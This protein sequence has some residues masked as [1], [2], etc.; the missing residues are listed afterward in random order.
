MTAPAPGRG[1]VRNL[2]P[3]RSQ[4]PW[5]APE[6]L[7]AL[8]VSDTPVGLAV[9]RRDDH[10]TVEVANPAFGGLLQMGPPRAAPAPDP[11]RAPAVG[12]RVTALAPLL[13][14]LTAGVTMSPVTLTTA[15]GWVR[16]HLTRIEGDRSRLVA[17][18]V[19]VT[20]LEL[21]LSDAERRAAFDELTGALNRASLLRHVASFLD[22]QAGVRAGA[23]LYGDIDDFKALNDAHGHAVGDEV[24]REVADRFARSAPRRAVVGRVGGDEFVIFVPD[25]PPEV[26]DAAVRALAR[27]LERPCLARDMLLQLSMSV[28][29][30]VFDSHSDADVEELLHR[31]DTAMY[32]VKDRRG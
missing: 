3:T 30:A 26:A 24:L 14:P 27:T 28:G 12:C 11:P 5:S 21:A 32:L 29:T 19:D 15:D 8:L 20:E 1:E 17:T 9:V 18:V 23:L 10:L 25:C 7:Q 4:G 31:A 6:D 13:G 22:R 16:L 2:D